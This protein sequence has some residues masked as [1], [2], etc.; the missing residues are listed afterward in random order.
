MPVGVR[1]P[2]LAL[3][4]RITTL[5]ED[6]VEDKSSEEIRISVEELS[7]TEKKIDVWVPADEV[8]STYESVL[9]EVR[10]DAKLRGFRKGKAPRS[11]I[12]SVYGGTIRG[13]VSE[14]L[15]SSTIEDAL[16]R[17][18]LSPVTTPRISPEALERGREFH[19]TVTL[20]V[21]PE[22][23]LGPY[24]GISIE[25][26]ERSVTDEEVE[27]Y[28][29]RLRERAAEAKPL[30]EDREVR[31][32][33]V[34]VLDYEGLLDGRSLEGL[35]QRGVQLVVGEGRL[36]EAFEEGL[37]GMRK[38]EEK[39]IEVTYDEGFA[40]EEAAGKT[41]RFKV[42]LNDVL[43]R[44]LPPLDDE[45]AKD[46]GAEDVEDLKKKV[47]EHLEAEL[48]RRRD[49]ARRSAVVRWIDEHNTF[50]VPRSLV[51]AEATRLR[52]DLEARMR[53]MGAEAPPLDEEGLAEL[54]MRA[55]RNVKVGIVLGRIAALEGI[56]VEED[57]VRRRLQETAEALGM[58]YDEVRSIYERG[59]LLR[60]VRSSILE[61]K[62]IDFLIK[63]ADIHPPAT[64]SDQIDKEGG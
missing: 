22:F 45:F 6:V 15:V 38:G 25:E 18:S 8:S 52:R 32:G 49:S 29:E 50:D 16:R 37:L 20:E 51:E 46:V 44:E 40:V 19:Y 13:E 41:V 54:R 42:R 28:I 39:E 26:E 24:K 5:G 31:K 11:V 14:R 9:A 21:V 56:E 43:E 2:P 12:E 35:T 61:E 10:R 60:G 59:D 33:D 53:G 7:S 4:P 30:A 64:P 3:H 63:N 36:V 48:R 58:N 34:V 1:L 27:D 62:V 23:E 17:S 57:E 55:E 47:R